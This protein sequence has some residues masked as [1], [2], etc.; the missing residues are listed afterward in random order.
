MFYLFEISRNSKRV[1]RTNTYVQRQAKM[2][3]Q[4]NDYEGPE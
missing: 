4:R 2:C 1:I 3:L